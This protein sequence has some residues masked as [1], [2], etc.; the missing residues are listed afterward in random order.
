LHPIPKKLNL[1]QA[2][3]GIA[4]IL[5]TL[6]HL[7]QIG[8]ERLNQAFLFHTFRF[9]WAGVDFFFVLSGFI[10]FYAHRSDIGQQSIKNFKVFLV[11]RFIRVYPIYWIVTLLVLCVVL[12]ISYLSKSSTIDSEFIIKSFLLYP[13]P[14]G[15]ILNVAWTLVQEVFFYLMFS[16]TILL[17]PKFYRPLVALVLLGSIMQLI[18]I[19]TVSESYPLLGVV[20]RDL[21]V[22][23]ALGCVAAYLVLNK[24]I[25]QTNNC[26][27]VGVFLFVLM[28]IFMDSNFILTRNIPRVIIC[29][30]PC[31]LIIIGAAIT[32]INKVVKVPNIFIYLGNASY[33]IYLIHGPAISA[34]TKYVLR[35][36]LEILEK[37][38]L[39]MSLLIGI[40]AI[41]FGCLF[42]SIV[43][44]PLL[45]F[46]RL[47]LVSKKSSSKRLRL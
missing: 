24:K 45:D 42:H 38:Y 21:N 1:L 3:R 11:K 34:A 8:N 46:L 15:Y 23:F 12:N 35:L 44:K 29:G 41:G 17:R 25:L 37:N 40:I 2:F 7:D 20:F 28:A 30:I 5:V 4:A 22:E 32:D 31:F 39:I 47:Q 18:G 36:K 26:L 13:Q 19:F 33:S 27:F 43:E 16:L 9:G 6:F 14:R 10:I